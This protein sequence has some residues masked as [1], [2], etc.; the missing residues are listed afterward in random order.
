MQNV[1]CIVIGAGASGLVAA[2]RAASG[3]KNVLVLERNERAGRKVAITGKGRC[4]VTNDTVGEEFSRNIVDGGKFLFSALRRFNSQDM[5]ALLTDAGVELK[6]ERG[7]R[8]FPVSDN[9]FDIVDGLVRYAKRGGA[10]LRFGVTVQSLTPC[11]NGGFLLGTTGGVYSAKDVII[12]TGGL[13]Y[14]STGSTGDGYA[15]A[16]RL[17][18]TVTPCRPGLIPLETKEKWTADLMGLSLK[19]TGLALRV[20]GKE[21]YTDFG[22]MLFTHFGVSGPMIISASSYLQ[23]YLKKEGLDCGADIVAELD[24]KPALSE[25]ELDKRLQ[26]EFSE[27]ALK[28]Y[29]TIL[30]NLLPAKMIPVFRVLSDIS[31][32][33]KGADLSKADRK[34]VLALLK[35]FTL[36]IV[37]TRP[38]E[39]AIITMGG[40]ATQETDPKTMESK[41][42]PGL[43]FA[44]EV[45][46][47]DAL[48][49]GF[50]L[51]LAFST[52]YAAGTAVLEKE[53]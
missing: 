20:N 21:I 18:H 40:I 11:E 35:H 25:E 48:T 13:S 41:L 47:I 10:A 16:E 52:G 7:Q 24:L 49:G 38:I 29:R 46:D 42:C 53:Y 45:L 12:A 23:A 2:G 51:Q 36:H 5:K 8:V 33:K 30:A 17:G 6:T 14:S 50:N 34:K 19:N 1:D 31:A 26:R 44:G 3:G 9:A 32:E 43:Y 22:E 28:N 37:G 27:G 39:E 4:N 15:W